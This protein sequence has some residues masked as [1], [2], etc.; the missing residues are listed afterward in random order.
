VRPDETHP[1]EGAM[2]TP[3]QGLATHRAGESVASPLVRLHGR[4]IVLAVDD[5]PAATS[6]IHVAA[7]LA[8]ECGVAVQAVDV[9]DYGTA[10]IMP[11]LDASRGF[12]DFGIGPEVQAEREVQLRKRLEATVGRQ[13]DWESCVVLGSPAGALTGQAREVDAAI[14]V[15]GLRAHGHV[16]RALHDETTLN[17]IRHA[18]CPVLAVTAGMTT[19][20]RRILVAID[21]SPNSIEAARSAVSIA[22][23]GAHVNL[24]Y[25]PASLPRM[26]EDGEGVV[27]DLGVKTA[28]EQLVAS[29]AT[30]EISISHVVLHRELGKG[31]AQVL[32]EYASDIGA[33]LIATGCV[34]RSIIQRMLVGSVSTD[35]VRQG[36]FSMLVAPFVAHH[37]ARTH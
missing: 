35:L 18:T 14:I 13:P 34:G 20:P 1:P 21:F 28:F 26:P 22:P 15:M 24:V 25:A 10:P 17:V 8:S 7:A 19:L 4:K 16:D 6:A 29:L 2:T 11:L 5:S 12:A 23:R 3:E 30:G 32:L 36:R 27:H 37:D 31:T 33:D 9:I